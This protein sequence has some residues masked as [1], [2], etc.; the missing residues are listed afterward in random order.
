MQVQQLQNLLCK[1]DA[2]E[3]VFVWVRKGN[4]ETDRLLDIIDVATNGG[5]QIELDDM[6]DDD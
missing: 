1:F 4:F 5:A 3:E 2:R 6:V